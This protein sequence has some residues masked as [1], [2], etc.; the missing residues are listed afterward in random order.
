MG[1]STTPE[2]PPARVYQLQVR[3]REDLLRSYIRKSRAVQKA[4]WW[5]LFV[6]LTLANAAGEL[7]FGLPAFLTVAFVGLIG[8]YITGMH[9]AEWKERLFELESRSTRALDM[10]HR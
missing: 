1:A 7:G 2:L 10:T 8:F 6:G 3:S 9:I 4:L 5:L